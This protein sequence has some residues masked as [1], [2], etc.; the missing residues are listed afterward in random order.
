M[1]RRFVL[2]VALALPAAAHQYQLGSLAIGH[3]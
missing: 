1:F 3:P 2:L